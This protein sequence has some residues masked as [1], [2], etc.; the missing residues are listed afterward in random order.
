MP[1][2]HLVGGSIP[3]GRAE[4]TITVYQA[5]AD[6]IGDHLAAIGV[7]DAAAIRKP[8]VESFIEQLLATRSPAMAN[9]RYRAL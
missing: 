2:K 9:N 7:H 8:Q 6:Q 4:A 3:S 1:S 5:A